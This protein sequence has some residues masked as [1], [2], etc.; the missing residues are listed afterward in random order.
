LKRGG[1]LTDIWD[2]GRYLDEFE[3]RDGQWKIINRVVV[4]DAERWSETFD[5]FKLARKN[6]PR[7]YMGA[8]GAKD[9]VH[10]LQSYSRERRPAYRYPGL[11]NHYRWLL[12]VPLFVLRWFAR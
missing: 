2:Q 11:W 9:P 10:D 7:A 6:T 3:R 1:K 12:G 4:V 5:F 8:R